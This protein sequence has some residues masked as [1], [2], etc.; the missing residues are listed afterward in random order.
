MITAYK[1]LPDGQVWL[2]PKLIDTENADKYKYELAEQYAALIKLPL[3]K[4]M[5]IVWHL[6]KE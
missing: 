5:Y 3:S 6:N 2:D 4:L 1:Q